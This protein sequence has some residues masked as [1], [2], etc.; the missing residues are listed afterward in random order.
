MSTPPTIML[1]VDGVWINA[2][3]VETVK[4]NYQASETAI[5]MKSGRVIRIRGTGDDK[6]VAMIDHA[7]LTVAG[8]IPIVETKFKPSGG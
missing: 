6:L 4:V 2:L 1:Y 7:L 8:M 3:E 5:T